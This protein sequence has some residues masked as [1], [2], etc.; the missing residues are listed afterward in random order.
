MRADNAGIT[1]VFQLGRNL[2][3]GGSTGSDDAGERFPKVQH[4]RGS[5]N[6]TDAVHER[7]T[8]K[9]AAVVQGV[10]PTQKDETGTCRTGSMIE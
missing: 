8:K 9:A 10:E 2:A 3:R 6:T 1:A 4:R 5:R 7:L